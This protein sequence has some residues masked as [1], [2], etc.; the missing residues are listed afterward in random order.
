MKKS[1]FVTGATNGTGYAIA[2]RFAKEGYDVFI[3]SRELERSQEA[4]EKI[5]N[6]YGVF[7]KGYAYR[8]DNLDEKGV[9]ALAAI[10][11]KEQLYANLACALSGTIRGLAVALNAIAEK[12]AEAN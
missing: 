8:A 10:P 9:K 5:A 12:K 7:A 1:V 4:A 3:G 6:D 2:A 11:S